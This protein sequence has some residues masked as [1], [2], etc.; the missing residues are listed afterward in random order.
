LGDSYYKVKKLKESDQSYEKALQ[1]NPNNAYV[2]NNYAYYL[3]LR[4]EQL[5]KAAAMSKRSN[6]LEA[7]NASFQDTYAWVLFKQK[8]YKDARVWI[9][10][11]IKINKDSGTQLEHYG[12]ILF[13]LGE[14]D[15]AVE[16]WN[17]A[18]SKGEKSETLEKKIYE[19]K[20]F[21]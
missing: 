14:K 4:N 16:Q 13:N 9:E 2:L 3:S 12:D 15:L 20:Y 1:F 10:K 8:N 11:A 6:E 7:D 19:K 5:E 18:K 17:L 21:E